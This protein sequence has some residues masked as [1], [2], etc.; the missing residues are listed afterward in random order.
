MTCPAE[1]GSG[2]V[3]GGVSPDGRLPSL[4]VILVEVLPVPG[5]CLP[6]DIVGVAFTV[7]FGVTSWP[8]DPVLVSPV[9]VPVPVPVAVGGCRW[10]RPWAIEDD[11]G[12]D[13][14]ARMPD[15]PPDELDLPVVRDPCGDLAT[16]GLLGP[17]GA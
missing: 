7:T 6:S 13:L 2:V 1:A 4:V 9:P 16:P 14:A 5:F 8:N 10:G 11:D 17:W 15:L 3:T 12:R